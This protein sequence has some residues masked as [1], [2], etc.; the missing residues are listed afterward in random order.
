[1]FTVSN[2]VLYNLAGKACSKVCPG[3]WTGPHQDLMYCYIKV[4]WQIF[5]LFT[6][7]KMYFDVF[8]FCY[9]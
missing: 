8:V 6:L 5:N 1:M 2:M 9:V 7:H 3:G 4:V